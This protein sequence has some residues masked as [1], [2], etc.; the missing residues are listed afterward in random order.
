MKRINANHST[1]S[2][3]RKDDVLYIHDFEDRP[4]YYAFGGFDGIRKVVFAEDIRVI[5]QNSIQFCRDLEEIVWPKDVR[6]IERDSFMDC[7][8]LKEIRFPVL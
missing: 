6:V 4:D 2:Y 1:N 5:P 3:H 7:R 8:S